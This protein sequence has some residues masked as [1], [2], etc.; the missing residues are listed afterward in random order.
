ML[1]AGLPDHPAV[2]DPSRRL[3]TKNRPVRMTVERIT[4]FLPCHSLHD[5][6][7][8]LEEADADALLS[9]WTAAWHPTLLAAVGA[10]P[11]WSS[12]DLPPPETTA[13]QIV[14]APW[15][16]R[17]AAQADDGRITPHRQVRGASG[18]DAVAAAAIVALGAEATA[19]QRLDR[20][21]LEDFHALGLAAL[22]ARLLA[23]RMRSAA[24]L[25]ST[26]F[27]A[28]AVLAARSAVA[29]EREA[30]QAGIRE[31]L[32]ILEATRARYYPVD[33]WL[34]DLV[35]LAETTLGAGLDREL[36]AAG[37]AALV[38][39][40]RVIETLSHRN[41][42]ALERVRQRCAAGTL[43][44]AGGRYDARP[45]DE[46]TPEEIAADLDRG[47]DAWRAHVGAVPTTFAQQTGGSSA[48][49]PQMLRDRGFGGCIW[50]LFDGTR[51]PDPSGSHIR[52][53]GSGGASIDAV[54][55]PPL[56]ARS[57]RMILALHESI[58]DAMD[59]DHTV[60]IPFAHHA[61]TAS[62]WFDA[63]R[64]IGAL[65]A[66]LGRFATPTEFFSSTAGG[67]TVASFE[68][69]AF[70]VGLPADAAGTGGD[71]VAAHVAAAKREARRLCGARA[72][73]GEALTP[74][75]VNPAAPAPVAAGIG[76]R[77]GGLF[78]RGRGRADDLVLEHGSLR[79]QVHPQTGGLLS[80]RGRADKGNRLSQRLALAT[81]RPA[82]RPAAAPD[83]P[84]D[85]A[86]YSAMVADRIERGPADG[87]R[88]PSLVSHGRLLDAEQRTVGEFTQRVELA[89]GLP[90]AVIDVEVRLAQ[91]PG[92]PLLEHHAACR[93]AWNEND[94]VELRRSLHTQSVVTERRRFTAPWYVEI[95]GPD[96]WRGRA[97][98][99]RVAIFTGGLP[100]HVLSSGHMLDSILPAGWPGG[101]A[102]TGARIAV[103]IG[104]E[105]PWDLAAAVLADLPWAACSALEHAAGVPANVRLTSGPVRR[106]GAGL[107][108]VRVGLLESAGRGGDVRL[109]WAAPVTRARM[110][111]PAGSPAASSPD[112]VV[113]DG[114]STSLFLGRYQ[115]RHLEVEFCP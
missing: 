58:G 50:T 110:I 13:L 112:G 107:A 59:H 35:L 29:G 84:A 103:G 41:P 16:E 7:T 66:C 96:E 10:T 93:F 2:A 19:A 39:T 70:P 42:A 37:P 61:G 47:L 90:L 92:G 21:L 45:L 12:V 54:A 31:C 77:Y 15:D 64:R 20:E 33:V 18:R 71:P 65:S 23:E 67:A 4:V 26:G 27:T 48:L 30:A 101:P 80:L 17:F 98:G 78:G 11:D 49:L 5:F 34:L 89:A 99:G 88:G 113:I 56:D 28:T 97:P 73:L 81:P 14:P 51:L 85:G 57:A 68:P 104:I 62:R 6:P 53:E 3:P 76:G 95:C 24:D 25:A 94:D 69:D 102:A 100:W 75:P 105:R 40:G 115:W 79:V 32:G 114:R 74:A 109:E 87:D 55:R 36:D 86:V 52:W 91:P 9:A 106:D 22:L 43:A 46:C 60:V 44:P 108:S 1:G 38:A 63:L 83:L 8:W 82:A 72:T 111:D